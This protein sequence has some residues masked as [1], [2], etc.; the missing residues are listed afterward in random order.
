MVSDPDILRM[1]DE[2]L[3]DL[4]RRF[5]QLHRKYDQY[6]LGMEP[7]E[8]GLL[9]ER[10]ERSLLKT[11][12]SRAQKT[13]VRYRYQQFLARYRTYTTNW[14]R[15]L[16]QIEEGTYRR[17]AV[18]QAERLATSQAES[19]V[20]RAQG[21]DPLTG[22]PYS[23]GEGGAA[24]EDLSADKRRIIGAAN[25]AQGFL[26]QMLSGGGASP[27]PPPRPAVPGP[28]IPRPAIPRPRAPGRT[29]SEIEQLY[30]AYV[31]AKKQRGEDTSKLSLSHFARSVKVQ[32][33]K[34]REKLGKDVE[35]RVKVTEKKVTL[36]AC[37]KRTPKPAE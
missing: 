30:S 36:V 26:K 17:A 34:A 9:R 8:P 35:L 24:G 13:S 15:V 1:Q 16:R 5:E 37:R 25:A 31:D 12:L 6:F 10:M 2:E 22:K 32:Q 27:P 29:R 20:M 23:G 19:A 33:N 4:C 3:A 21:I 18:T 28:A 11:R 7:R 14:D